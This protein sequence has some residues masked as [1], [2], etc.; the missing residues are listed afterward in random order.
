M[1]SPM[2]SKPSPPSFSTSPTKSK[3]PIILK[4]SG[5]SVSS[6]PS[7]PLR[8]KAA[9]KKVA[10]PKPPV[11]GAFDHVAPKPSNFRR[12]YERGDL[13]IAVEHRANGNTLT[14]K[15][16]PEDL[17][18]HYYLP[19][20]FDG[21]SEE[22]EPYRF[23]AR[24]GV[25]NMLE[26]G[27]AKIILVLPQLIIPIKSALN[28]RNPD[29]ICNILHVLQKLVLSGDRVGEAL[30]PYYHQILPIFNLFKN[31][32]KNIGDAIDYSQ[33]KRE[34]I[35]DLIQETLNLFEQHGGEHA[36]INI[37]YMIPTYESCMIN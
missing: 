7:S 19:I 3:A 8:A 16:Q 15:V 24:E 4:P 13:P 36:F 2:K 30:V 10:S 5:A 14:W 12:F 37:K 21:L 25:N 27:G 22:K 28:T 31:K 26:R 9:P 32:N 34:N 23:L 33:R 20:F 17:D 1:S 29:T 18:Y 6:S 35:G 11:A